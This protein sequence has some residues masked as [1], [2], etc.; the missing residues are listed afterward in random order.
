MAHDMPLSPL[1]L[2]HIVAARVKN[3]LGKD[4]GLPRPVLEKDMAD[5][6]RVTKRVLKSE[7][8]SG[9]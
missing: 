3:S 5:C 4:G 1:P 8:M 2:A 6:A 7:D 9:K